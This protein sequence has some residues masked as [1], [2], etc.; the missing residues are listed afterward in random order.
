MRFPDR[1]GRAL[2]DGIS[3]SG[4]AIFDVECEVEWC[5]VGATG[6]WNGLGKHFVN[7]AEWDCSGMVIP[8]TTYG[9]SILLADSRRILD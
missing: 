8:K 3:Y 6:E 5:G 2:L 9:N 1:D 4:R 7:Y